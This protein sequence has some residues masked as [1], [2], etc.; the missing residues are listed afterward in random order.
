MSTVSDHPSDNQFQRLQKS[1]GKATTNQADVLVTKWGSA[2]KGVYFVNKHSGW[3]R[4][5]RFCRA[6]G[7]GKSDIK[8]S[9]Q[10]AFNSLINVKTTKPK[11]QH[12][13]RKTHIVTE[14]QTQRDVRKAVTDLYR[15][16]VE[17]SS[18]AKWK[19][20][21]EKDEENFANNLGGGAND[22]SKV[23][24]DCMRALPF[25]ERMELAEN[26][27][28]YTQEK[29]SL[30]T[31]ILPKLL[32]RLADLSKTLLPSDPR[33]VN[34]C[35]AINLLTPPPSEQPKAELSQ[36]FDSMFLRGQGLE[37]VAS[38]KPCT[39][40]VANFCNLPEKRTENDSTSTKALSSRLKKAND[41]LKNSIDL[42]QTS[43]APEEISKKVST[44][45]STPGS[46][47]ILLGTYAKEGVVYEFE[48]Q[49]DNK[50]TLKIF[51]QSREI[52]PS[53]QKA[54]KIKETSIGCKTIENIDLAKQE[55]AQSL[56]TT[57]KSS[58]TLPAV[59]QQ[60]DMYA[61]LMK[62]VK[63][64]V[65][66]TISSEARE[67]SSEG[68]HFTALFAWLKS[69]Y[70][71]DTLQYKHDKYEMKK[72]LFDDFLPQLLQKSKQP[73]NNSKEYDSLVE[74]RTRIQRSKESFANWIE[75]NNLMISQDYSL[76]SGEEQNEVNKLFDSYAGALI[77][78]D[79]QLMEFEKK[80]SSQGPSTPLPKDA[81]PLTVD[82]SRLKTAQDIIGKGELVPYNEPRTIHLTE[83]SRNVLQN[84][85]DGNVTGSLIGLQQIISN[86]S[87]NI[88]LEEVHYVF[89]EICRKVGHDWE[90]MVGKFSDPETAFQV[91]KDIA[92]YIS[93]KFQF[94]GNNSEK[95]PLA[96]EYFLFLSAQ[97][98]MECAFK[99]I[100][101]NTEAF[102]DLPSVLANPEIQKQIAKL[103][104]SDPLW[105]TFKEKAQT[106]ASKTQI[107]DLG[108]ETDHC[109]VI[110][111]YVKDWLLSSGQTAM[112]NAL[113]TS[114]LAERKEQLVKIDKQR[115]EILPKLKG[116]EEK[117]EV[118]KKVI[119][120]KRQKLQ[121]AQ[122]DYEKWE[123]Y[124]NHLQYWEQHK[125][126][127]GSRPNKP[128][129][130]DKNFVP[131]T[132]R[133]SVE[134][135]IGEWKKFQQA[136]ETYNSSLQGNIPEPP[137]GISFEIAMHV[138]KNMQDY[139][140]LEKFEGYDLDQ[141]SFNQACKTR[142]FDYKRGPIEPNDTDCTSFGHAAQKKDQ[143][144][145]EYEEEDK[146]LHDLQSQFEELK[147]QYNTTIPDDVIKAGTWPFQ[148]C[149][150]P[151]TLYPAETPTPSTIS[152]NDINSG[153][154]ASLLIAA[155]NDNSEAKKILYNED[156][157]DTT[158]KTFCHQNSTHI[159][160]RLFELRYWQN[161]GRNIFSEHQ[162]FQAKD[163]LPKFTITSS[164]PYGEYQLTTTQEFASKSLRPVRDIYQE[165]MGPEQKELYER[166]FHG[167]P[168]KEQDVPY[169]ADHLSQENTIPTDVAK[170]ILSLK[171]SPEMQVLSTIEYM[172]T[173]AQKLGDTKWANLFHSLIFESN[174]LK[175]E[176]SDIKKRSILIARCQD[177]INS[178]I[179]SCSET[180]SYDAVAN[181]LWICSSIQKYIDGIPLE[182]GEQRPA[183]FLA[184]QLKTALDKARTSGDSKKAT[185]LFEAIAI[186]SAKSLTSTDHAMRGVH[187]LARVMMKQY[188]VSA[189]HMSIPRSE[190]L[191]KAEFKLRELV[192]D[193]KVTKEDLTEF[194]NLLKQSFPTLNIED[195]DILKFEN[196]LFTIDDKVRVSVT[197]GEA[198]SSIQGAFNIAQEQ[199]LSQEIIALLKNNNFYPDSASFEAAVC[200]VIPQKDSEVTH[201]KDTDKNLEFKFIKSTSDNKYTI[202]VKN[203]KAGAIN[204]W[205]LF[206]TS[207]QRDSQ[208]AA[209]Q[210]KYLHIL[211][212][213]EGGDTTLLLLDPTSYKTVYTGK[214][215]DGKTR[216]T[217]KS[218]QQEPQ[219]VH[220]ITVPE[221]SN[222]ISGLE[223]AEYSIFLANTQGQLQQIELPRL[224]LTLV[225]NNNEWG[226]VGKEG[227]KVCDSQFVP[228]LRQTKG[229]LLLEDKVS[230]AKKVLF[231]VVKPKKT[232]QTPEGKIGSWNSPYEYDF[233]PDP[234][235]LQIVECSLKKAPGEHQK[236][237]LEPND[238]SGRFYLAKMY[239]ERGYIDDAENLMN[240]LLAQ[241][242][243][244]RFSEQ[245][246][247]LLRDL[248]APPQSGD[249][250]V[251]VVRL[252]MHALA[253]LEKN[254]NRFPLE[255]E[256]KPSK[257][258]VTGDEEILKEQ[259][260]LVLDYLAKLKN[261]APLERRQ[262][263]ELLEI[264]IPK[265]REKNLVVEL[266]KQLPPQV[267]SPPEQSSGLHFKETLLPL[268]KLVHDTDSD[269]FLSNLVGSSGAPTI[270][271]DPKN[272]KYLVK[273]TRQAQQKK[274]STTQIFSDNCAEVGTDPALK[275]QFEKMAKDE[276]VAQK[277]SQG[278]TLY[279]VN[280]E[281]TQESDVI[282]S[283][284]NTIT[285]KITSA[286]HHLS[287]M[288][289][290]ITQTVAR[291]LTS[292]DNKGWEEYVSKKR[293]L[294][295]IDELCVL[296]GCHG[297]NYDRHVKRLYPGISDT[298]RAILR[299]K[300][301]EY[302]TQKQ[303]TQRLGRSQELLNQIK[304]NDEEFSKRFPSPTMSK[305]AEV[306]KSSFYKHQKERQ[307]LLDSL[308]VSPEDAALIE[309]LDRD[310]AKTT[311]PADHQKKRNELLQRLHISD[312]TAKKI[313]Q[314]D[315]KYQED[316]CKACSDEEIR[317]EIVNLLQDYVDS[318]QILLNDLGK[319]LETK[320]AY[321]STNKYAMSF[322]LM[323]TVLKI[324][325]RKDQIDNITKFAEN[326]EKGN[327]IAL[328]MI[329]GAGKT[330]V[331][332]PILGYLFSV[333]TTGPNS[334]TSYSSVTV[335]AQLFGKVKDELFKALGTSFNQLVVV[336]P[337]N[338]NLGKN[339]EYLKLYLKELKEAQAN[340]SCELRVPKQ[341]QS[342]L[343][344]LYE[345]YF[346][347]NK[348]PNDSEKTRLKER[349]T[350]I[351]EICQFF[352]ENEC[353]QVD[354]IDLVANPEVVFKYP[355]GEKKIV[356][357]KRAA[358]ISEMLWAIAD[359]DELNKKVSIPFCEK[360]RKRCGK[361]LPA[362]TSPELLT[363]DSFKKIVLP[364]LVEKAIAIIE[365][366]ATPDAFER[367]KGHLE[368]IL[369]HTTP[370]A[371]DLLKVLNELKT[372]QP[373]LCEIIGGLSVA[374]TQFMEDTLL[375]TEF[376]WETVKGEVVPG[377]YIA[378]P[379]HQNKVQDTTFENPY[380]GVILQSILAIQDGVPLDAAKK[381]LDQLRTRVSRGESGAITEFNE[382]MGSNLF[383]FMQTPLQPDNLKKF[384]EAVSKN[385]EW[386]LKY[387]KEYA[388]DQ[389]TMA[390][391]SLSCTAHAQFGST[392][393][394]V[395]YTGTQ[396]V[397]ILPSGMEGI[398]EQGTDALTF[399]AVHKKNKAKTSETLEMKTKS[400]QT[401][402]DDEIERFKNDKNLFVFIDSGGWLKEV[403]MSDYCKKMLKEVHTARPEIQGVV[404]LNDE[405]EGEPWI[406]EWRTDGDPVLMPLANSSLKTTSGNVLTIMAQQYE[407]GTNIPQKPDAKADK[408]IRRG[409]TLRD[410]LQAIFR[411][412]QILGGQNINLL[413]TQEVK[414]D[415][416]HGIVE[417]CISNQEIKN[418]F[419][420][421][422]FTPENI[423]KNISNLEKFLKAF[424]EEI[425]TTFK[426][427]YSD[428]CDNSNRGD[429]ARDI[430]KTFKDAFTD[431]LEIS[432]ETVLRY[433]NVNQARAEQEK[434]WTAAQQKMRELVEKPFRQVLHDPKVSIEEGQKLFKMLE[435]FLIETS[436]DSPFN[437][438]LA[439]KKV[440][441]AQE[442]IN[443]KV[444]EFQKIFTAT[445][446]TLKTDSPSLH[447]Q[448]AG[449]FKECYPIDPKLKENAKT[450]L[451]AILGNRLKSVVEAVDIPPSIEVSAAVV[452]GEAETE[453]QQ[454]AESQVEQQQEQQLS[455]YQKPE[456]KL[457]QK[458]VFASMFSSLSDFFSP[459][460]PAN[461]CVNPLAVGLP[462]I[463][464]DTIGDPVR[465]MYYSRN[466]FMQS[467]S[468]TGND[469]D[470]NSDFQNAYRLA[471]KYVL[472]IQENGKP[473]KYV[474]V[475]DADAAELR[476][477][478]LTDSLTE[479][480]SCSLVSLNTRQVYGATNKDPNT[481]SD[482]LKGDHANLEFALAKLCTGNISFTTGE[483]QSLQKA[484]GSDKGKKEGIRTFYE[485]IIRHQKDAFEN[486]PASAVNV[487]IFHSTA[488]PVATPE[489]QE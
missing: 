372:Q 374:I 9:V 21:L 324:T 243:H 156:R 111:N 412:R 17:K 20:T 169:V 244:K 424:P 182:Q 250:G 296:A 142:G 93:E 248:C 121:K 421:G 101:S 62:G 209:L 148:L 180:K 32:H 201:F 410:G 265:F 451:E 198:V 8:K 97:I 85:H 477:K 419:D 133:A 432:S 52:S 462:Q 119:E 184:D 349:I 266:P 281:P 437:Q 96:D 187:L 12:L 353:G 393:L 472:V 297:E 256:S 254:I 406:V 81:Q 141:W 98:A 488:K 165:S 473:N 86:P 468:K 221:E 485:E 190:D 380:Q 18:E 442:A 382:L 291:I 316:L 11:P 83:S 400:T 415:I 445:M 146:K 69:C 358:A 467:N 389:V 204:D 453:T 212:K 376:G 363:K 227:W 216:L 318:C 128:N 6:L 350:L 92:T 46:R 153:N 285:E 159:P 236:E 188:P 449:S 134:L 287:E 268:K 251:R 222:P 233:P 427:A 54:E 364:K 275:K 413:V 30:S 137:S 239:L 151:P 397:K 366:Q 246:Q 329:M 10:T 356:D 191:K 360:M 162:A 319:S 138:I 326:V 25:D 15:E 339:N 378:R 124:N 214:I 200:T 3:G 139:I 300:L 164:D 258:Q 274:T 315:S 79:I 53:E 352:H 430:L 264:L 270:D 116:L 158:W 476:K 484:I 105:V 177:L 255:D 232:T 90:K 481:I 272:G 435:N 67:T 36:V 404:F 395:G 75:K 302:L 388:Y 313:E 175:Q 425:Q 56:F 429:N 483:I 489:A 181:A 176:V 65:P 104:T 217:K 362:G 220:V 77:Q 91:F 206:V 145:K 276:E 193:N 310:P 140:T 405:K 28:Q 112:K 50:V 37:A 242:P 267:T 279:T 192:D 238:Y 144:Q 436:P 31:L 122:V 68:S 110:R 417:G 335:P 354:E 102:K 295:T 273:T 454:Q 434:N 373:E 241:A 82:V 167:E 108:V 330:S 386:T 66:P 327:P 202:L 365:K 170:E 95:P 385:K 422:S 450:P 160:P 76:L 459:Q 443:Q 387:F 346:E 426:K 39:E 136:A 336:L 60:V 290:K 129:Y 154:I 361:Q 5:I 35:S 392:K 278:V 230:G 420:I 409:E 38:W 107:P 464:S 391:Q 261:I 396:H 123:Q 87:S 384:Q 414:Q 284:L 460:F 113:S 423:K 199:P 143:A 115:K 42:Q 371:P 157:T 45:L 109:S 463:V 149:P 398:P 343:T 340:G 219:D 47:C 487:A 428:L 131:K 163:T 465:N 348:A 71:D 51:A 186:A 305:A 118:Q 240:D 341:K 23:I 333:L 114:I 178:L 292:P 74:L 359:D 407:T 471:A 452:G 224:G 357:H 257:T 218:D 80:N 282:G 237:R 470:L 469:T 63:T 253:I 7:L 317:Q 286:E 185:L 262:E 431:H 70:G 458:P 2:G 168:Y 26:I 433:L 455:A 72:Q 78:L 14:Q 103:Q 345:A 120:E 73:I 132:K 447:A 304:R 215:E 100:A 245:E 322:L 252:R 40:C 147:T 383:D 189:Q 377:R 367:L 323:E 303:F 411:M 161:R 408:S 179:L 478:F 106:G 125:D 351:K 294:P 418:L 1:F 61:H 311:S 399:G 312:D 338:R 438:M 13:Q 277:K 416:T 33:I 381:M 226:V 402:P 263:H 29:A 173:H 321:D 394:N 197:T 355:V 306:I 486:Y 4:W 234:K 207:D 211:S 456:A 155:A 94:S 298:D 480:K 64:Y 247:S 390:Q 84:L 34:L 49:Q 195:S 210:K 289:E 446:S 99:N 369:T 293:A 229:F 174:L 448:V 441:S 55:L 288:G 213:K 444:A 135:N 370:Y 482:S 126:L 466:L 89:R 269:T 260:A 301:R 344:S 368:T 223:S 183:I 334:K 307:K 166:M 331:L 27:K 117:I 259:H 403:K 342:V 16:C 22:T 225:N 130:Q 59:L 320:S 337:Y 150:F 41:L 379:Y 479:G 332:Q 205:S 328:Q 235:P 271:K 228:N 299:E 461:N 208:N 309:R 43:L 474:L 231:P 57:M 308:G 19:T 440:I 457:N 44:Q 194:K 172:H 283:Q 203:I 249:R 475:S 314:S 196:G 325:L 24:L 152:E 401:L 375:K 439:E 88:S 280:G 127:I 48:R 347:L 171:A 58:T